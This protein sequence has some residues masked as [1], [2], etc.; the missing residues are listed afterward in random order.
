MWVR[1]P[2]GARVTSGN[3]GT[4]VAKNANPSK[5]PPFNNRLRDGLGEAKL[6]GAKLGAVPGSRKNPPQEA[7]WPYKS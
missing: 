3:A 2:L 7:R 4:R 6:G 5:N 1:V